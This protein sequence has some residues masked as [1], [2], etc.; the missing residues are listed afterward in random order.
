MH[1]AR[2]GLVKKEKARCRDGDKLRDRFFL[3]SGS[4]FWIPWLFE[5]EKYH[6]VRKYKDCMDTHIDAE[7]IL[8]FSDRVV[9]NV[10]Y[11]RDF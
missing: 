7:E 6:Y 1:L 11:R 2:E 8:I 10:E 5:Y 3:L 9:H 4:G